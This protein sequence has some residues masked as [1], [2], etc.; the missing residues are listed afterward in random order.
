MDKKKEPKIKD[1]LHLMDYL[2]NESYKDY[3]IL[4]DIKVQDITLDE[5]KYYVL[6]LRNRDQMFKG[7][8]GKIYINKFNCNYKIRLV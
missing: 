4:K 1:S 5:I 8:F 3:E 2:I 6:K 7:V